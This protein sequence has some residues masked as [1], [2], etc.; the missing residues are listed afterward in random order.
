M[1]AGIPLWER[2]DGTY[3]A[4]GNRIEAQNTLER[5]IAAA[6][7]RYV[8]A[9]AFAPVYVGLGAKNQAFKWLEKSIEERSP[10]MGTT[11]ALG[12]GFDSLRSDPR[13]T[14]LLHR[15]NLMP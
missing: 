12:A 9:Y 2:S 14:N 10:W 11:L 6:K 13:F 4:S 1:E 8:P 5:L 15:M 3:A 7:D